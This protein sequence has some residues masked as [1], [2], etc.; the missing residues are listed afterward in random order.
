M[1]VSTVQQNES[2]VCI[3]ISPL[4]WISFPFR[5]PQSTEQSSLC[6]S[7]G[8]Y[9]LAILY[10]VPMFLNYAEEAGQIGPTVSVGPTRK[11]LD[12]N[13]T[14]ADVKSSLFLTLPHPLCCSGLDIG[15]FDLACFEH[16]S[17]LE[18]LFQKTDLCRLILL[19]KKGALELFSFS[20][21]KCSLFQIHYKEEYKKSK[22]KCMFVT[23]TPMLN[24]VKHIGAFI[25]EVRYQN[26]LNGLYYFLFM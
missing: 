2:A 1:L 12:G 8:S 9:E 10:V 24:H 4:F 25:S 20:Y 19:F 21:V 18:Y 11:I 26:F 7:I 15:L 23:D 16:H 14:L 3:H 5:P 22:G 13:C 17:T 6:Y